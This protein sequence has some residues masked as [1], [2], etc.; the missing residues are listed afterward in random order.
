MFRGA[1]VRGSV[2]CAVETQRWKLRAKALT[3]LIKVNQF[4]G[5]T[6]L[7][8]AFFDSERSQNFV[9]RLFSRS[10]AVGDADAAV[11]VA[12]QG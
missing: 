10:H 6:A 2:F 7:R 4:G 1:V 11:G 5:G 8:G 12:R 3:F 9:Y